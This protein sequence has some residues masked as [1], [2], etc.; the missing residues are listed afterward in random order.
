MDTI[1]QRADHLANWIERDTSPARLRAILR[2][3]LRDAEARGEQRAD[4][5]VEVAPGEWVPLSDFHTKP[6]GPALIWAKES[7]AA[8][9][10]AREA[11]AAFAPAFEASS[12]PELIVINECPNCGRDAVGLHC[13]RCN[14]SF[15]LGGT[16]GD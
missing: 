14:L 4:Q 7:A 8:L 1:E 12:T 3:A 11:L 2:A 10:I 5:M 13:Y 15:S 9:D 6:A 16:I